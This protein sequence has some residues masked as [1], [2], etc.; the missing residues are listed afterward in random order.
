[1]ANRTDVLAQNVHGMDPQNLVEYILRMRIYNSRYWKE[2]CFGLN[3]ETLVEKAVALDHIG[4]TFGGNRKPTP[5]MCLVL[6]LLQIQPPLEACVE[7][8]KQ[9][10]HKYLRA[11]GSF[12]MRLVGNPTEVYTFLE[13]LF[14]DYRKLAVRTPTGWELTH[15]DEL[16]DS[17]LRDEHVWDMV[18]PKLP[19]RRLLESTGKLAPRKSVLAKLAEAS[20]ATASSSIRPDAP[21]SAGLKHASYRYGR[22]HSSRSRDE[23][24]GGDTGM[25]ERLLAKQRAAVAAAAETDGEGAARGAYD[26]D[27]PRRASAA[28]SSSRSAA[29]SSSFGRDAVAAPAV[30]ESMSVEEWNAH[31]IKLGMRPLRR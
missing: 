13:P 8:I 31:R 20:A 14:T 15:V 10:D 9:D 24:R 30:K 1:M 11:L 6:K 19:K 22:D 28:V 21:I 3:A 23:D 16:I 2:H 18:L 25:A 27:E 4:G 12:Y 26:D 29:T 17:L 5:F 7:Y